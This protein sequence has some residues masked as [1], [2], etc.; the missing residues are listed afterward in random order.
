MAIPVRPCVASWLASLLTIALLCDSTHGSAG[1][2]P[3]GLRA[4]LTKLAHEDPRGFGGEL[5]TAH[6]TAP[7]AIHAKQKGYTCELDGSTTMNIYP[8]S[9]SLPEHMFLPVVPAKSQH[10]STVVPGIQ[11][12]L[13]SFTYKKEGWDCLRHPE[14]VAAGTLP[15]FTDIDAVPDGTL[16]AHPLAVYKLLKNWPGLSVHG[17]PGTSAGLSSPSSLHKDPT[18]RI[19]FTGPVLSTRS[20]AKQ[21]MTVANISVESRVLFV[22][23]ENEGAD[24]QCE[25]LLHGFV[26]IMSTNVVDYPRRPSIWINNETF[27]EAE[28]AGTMINEYGSGFGYAHRLYEPPG[29][30]DRSNIEDKIKSGMFDYVVFGSAHRAWWRESV[31]PLVCASLPKDKVIVVFDAAQYQAQAD[32]KIQV[33]VAAKLCQGIAYP[34]KDNLQAGMI[35]AGW[36]EHEGGSVWGVNLG[37]TTL[38]SSFATGGS[39]S[40]YIYGFCDKFWKDNMTEVEAKA[41]VVRALGHAMARDASSGGCIRTVTLNKDGMCRDFIPGTDV[42]LCYDDMPRGGVVRA[43]A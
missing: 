10:F 18:S 17:L 5:A 15:I 21:V 28:L 32:E 6:L 20:M 2:L 11:E 39:G 43:V 38:K 34:N 33:K 1:W 12:T 7:Y 29:V 9:F 13:F 25:T 42:P 16:A 37:G 22:T 8:I 27:S 19:A 30:V 3:L 40:A 14:I 35:V 36:D 31:A 4:S 41:F 24:Y 23:D 26:T